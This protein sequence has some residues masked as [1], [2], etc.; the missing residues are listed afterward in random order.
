MESGSLNLLEPSGSHRACYGTA[1]PLHY[2]L[3]LC[4]TFVRHANCSY[5]TYIIRLLNC[6]PNS[7]AV[8]YETATVL[9]LRLGK[10]PNL[11]QEEAVSF[12]HVVVL[13]AL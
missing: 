9:D 10:Y 3:M 5:V 4:V 7:V 12:C 2:V 6:P 1:L 8:P 13:F 11:S